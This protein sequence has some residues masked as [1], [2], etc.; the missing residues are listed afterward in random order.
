MVC[1]ATGPQNSNLT[2][3]IKEPY[4]SQA[5]YEPAHE[6]MAQVYRIIEQ[7]KLSQACASL[8]NNNIREYDD[9]CTNRDPLSPHVF[10]YSLYFHIYEVERLVDV[11]VCKLTCITDMYIIANG[12]GRRL[13]VLLDQQE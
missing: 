6:I 3:T 12:Y 10:L 2:N 13:L 4:N 5:I 1:N 7:L 11:C 8:Q 9:T